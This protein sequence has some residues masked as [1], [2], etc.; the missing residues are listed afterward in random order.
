MI[1]KKV[2]FNVI[3]YQA[4]FCLWI[5]FEMQSR[6]KKNY[7]TADFLFATFNTCVK[8]LSLILIWSNLHPSQH[9][10][11]GVPLIPNAG[12]IYTDESNLRVS[13]GAR[14][15]N[16]TVFRLITI[17]HSREKLH[18]HESIWQ[19]WS[20]HFYNNDAADK[21]QAHAEHFSSW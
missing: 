1:S 9:E 21:I 19:A 4:L 5:R 10:R 11:G 2:C 17:L 3:W 8:C 14:E 6:F 15:R 20:F 7:C 13:A 12:S 16:H 18:L